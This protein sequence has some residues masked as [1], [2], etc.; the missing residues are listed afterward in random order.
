[1]KKLLKKFGQNPLRNVGRV[2]HRSVTNFSIL[3]KTTK[4]NKSGK[5]SQNTYDMHY[6]T[7]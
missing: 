3:K 2:E 1:M 4:G 7:W 6:G 5:K